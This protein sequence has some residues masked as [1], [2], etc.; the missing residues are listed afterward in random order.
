[1]KNTCRRPLW[2]FSSLLR[3]IR[4][5]TQRG[6]GG[7]SPEV[8]RLTEIT[9]GRQTLTSLG[10]NARKTEGK[11]T[12]TFIWCVL[13]LVLNFVHHSLMLA[14]MVVDEEGWVLKKKRFD[15]GVPSDLKYPRHIH[16]CLETSYHG[17][18]RFLNRFTGYDKIIAIVV[19]TWE[20]DKVRWMRNGHLLRYFF[21]ELPPYLH[22]PELLS[23]PGSME[24]LLQSDGRRF[25][26]R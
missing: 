20:R 9:L 22:N 23:T 2:V 11:V 1:M 4:F 13:K 3:I 16:Q 25:C 24:I 19:G 10:T 18:A 6:C 15:F 21:S 5:N 7:L 17:T 12:S 14:L 26:F 8:V